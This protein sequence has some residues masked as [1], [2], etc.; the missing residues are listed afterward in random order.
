MEF[1][2]GRRDLREQIG[3]PSEAAWLWKCFSQ[4][5]TGIRQE[6]WQ[7]EFGW[8]D[9]IASPYSDVNQPMYDIW[10]IYV[11][12]GICWNIPRC[13][14]WFVY[15]WWG[16]LKFI[17]HVYFLMIIPTGRAWLGESTMHGLLG[18][19][20]GV[21]DNWI[22]GALN[23]WLFVDLFQKSTNSIQQKRLV[24]GIGFFR[25]SGFKHLILSWPKKN[26][27]K[28]GSK[29]SSLAS[30]QELQDNAPSKETD[31]NGKSAQGIDLV[32]N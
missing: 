11:C 31:E 30:L 26:L 18:C 25:R 7:F 13:Q 29:W 21:V 6:W 14:I 12:H 16:W 22:L 10:S 1:G 20:S 27:S 3:L 9:I 32:E 23:A 15:L 5:S 24:G 19:M 17:F 4:F 8:W 28:D 2:P